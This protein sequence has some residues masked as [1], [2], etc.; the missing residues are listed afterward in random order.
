[1]KALIVSFALLSAT[2]QAD[3]F[4]FWHQDNEVRSQSGDDLFLYDQLGDRYAKVVTDGERVLEKFFDPAAEKAFQMTLGRAVDENVLRGCR[5]R[6]NNP[7]YFV[8]FHQGNSCILT[9]ATTDATASWDA[10]D[11]IGPEFAKVELFDGKI[12][13][14]Y[15]SGTPLYQCVGEYVMNETRNCF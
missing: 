11:R 14:S 2:A 1:M 7:R 15:G 13:Q 5:S 4:T 3:T 8:Y 6:D 12:I 9:S 10:Y